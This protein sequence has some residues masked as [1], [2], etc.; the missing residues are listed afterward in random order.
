MPPSLTLLLPRAPARP[1]FTCLSSLSNTRKVV[2]ILLLSSSSHFY[3]SMQVEAGGGDV[4][5]AGPGVQPCIS[6][7]GDA[8]VLLHNLG[9]AA[10]GGGACLPIPSGDHCPS[11]SPG[12][13][14]VTSPPRDP[15]ADLAAEAYGAAEND[16]AGY[17][18]SPWKETE[19][20][21]DGEDGEWVNRCAYC[22]TRMSSGSQLCGRTFCWRD[23]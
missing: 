9:C 17:E 13:D 2:P 21:E 6:L 1:G 14:S 4:D 10:A 20:G 7:V 5:G 22:G 3:L 11:T 16:S 12:G 15:D 19:D 18:A 23:G 8:I